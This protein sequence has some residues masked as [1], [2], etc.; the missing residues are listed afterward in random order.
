V[1]RAQGGPASFA[2]PIPSPENTQPPISSCWCLTPCAVGAVQRALPPTGALAFS[3]FRRLWPAAERKKRAAWPVAEL[4]RFDGDGRI[5]AEGK[6]GRGALRGLGPPRG[7]LA[8]MIVGF[9][10]Q[11]VGHGEPWPLAEIAGQSHR[12]RRAWWRHSISTIRLECLPPRYDRQKKRGRRQGRAA[13]LARAGGA[14]QGLA[15]S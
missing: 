2:G 11:F 14:S 15:A 7:G 10:Q 9:R 6:R 8:G 5:T 13:P 12:G 4:A 1:G 3:R